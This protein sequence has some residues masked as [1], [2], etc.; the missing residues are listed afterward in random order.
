MALADLTDWLNDHAGEGFVWFVKRL[1]GNDT[2][3]N[4]S[5]QAGPY[6]PKDFLFRMFPSIAR[7]DTKN[8][9]H[10]FDLYVDSHAD[11]RQIRAVYYNTRP[12]R[13]GTRDESRL[14]NFGGASSAL[15]DPDSTGALT[16]FAF[17]L[18]N[19]GSATDCHVW[20]CRHA[21]EED[22]II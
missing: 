11:H 17:R 14:T 19:G 4:G 15:L 16:V 2:L 5:H 10:R 22:L 12:R 6:I 9:D 7:I 1:T 21:T 8:P 20:V 3:A 18:G 13:E